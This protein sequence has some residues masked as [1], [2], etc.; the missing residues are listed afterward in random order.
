[1]LFIS[2]LF[3]INITPVAMQT[4]TMEIKDL[5]SLVSSSLD[6]LLEAIDPTIDKFQNTTLEILSVLED[7]IKVN[8]SE[9]LYWL[10]TN[11]F[12]LLFAVIVFLIFIFLL[13]NLLDILLVRYRYLPEERRFVGL[14]V[15]TII[16]VWLF[17]AMILST[18]PPTNKFN[19]QTLT[20]VL[21]GLLSLIVLYLIII[22]ICYLYTHRTHIPDYFRQLCG[23]GAGNRVL[24]QGTSIKAQ[25]YIEL[26][27]VQH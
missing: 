23:C 19:L 21:V 5:K 10:E 7:R 9:T 24:V 1:M 3:V 13:L 27:T 20:Y 15:I 17:I 14:V 16:F 26:T 11:L 6:R 18:W 8:I 12:V 25:E 4:I 22:W 2:I